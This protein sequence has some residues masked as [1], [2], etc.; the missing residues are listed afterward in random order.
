MGREFELKYRATPEQLEAIHRRHTG[1]HTITMETIYYDTPTGELSRRR[2]TLR[3]RMEN[4]SPVCTLKIG[5]PDGSRGEWEVPCPDILEA[6][7]GLIALGAPEELA[8]I[9]S[10]G[11]A[12]TCGAKFTRR[13]ATV[14]TGSATV[15]IALDQGI[16]L[17]GGKELPLCEAEVELKSGPDGDAIAF[18]KSLAAAIGLT[19]ETKSKLARAR[20]LAGL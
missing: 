12:P 2:W 4:G 9:V 17:G 5:L 20:T 18:A 8:A 10:Q 14:Q 3:R 13:A 1:W 16:L 15:E 11:I 6:I 19:P 7:S